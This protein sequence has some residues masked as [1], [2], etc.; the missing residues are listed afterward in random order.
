LPDFGPVYR[1]LI[2]AGVYKNKHV[3]GD[4]EIFSVP[5]SIFEDRH[6]PLVYKFLAKNGPLQILI[7]WTGRAGRLPN[8]YPPSREKSNGW[9]LRSE[10]SH[11]LHILHIKIWGSV[12]IERPC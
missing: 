2:V 6:L 8:L 9:G 5:A 1:G 4:S 12:C 11:L 10:L 3:I 7:G